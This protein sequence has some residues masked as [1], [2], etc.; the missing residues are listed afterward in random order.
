MKDLINKKK[1]IKQQRAES[2]EKAVCEICGK[3]T[4]TSMKQLEI[5]M[6]AKHK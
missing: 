3:N 6:K 2:R 5:H 1:K 4:F